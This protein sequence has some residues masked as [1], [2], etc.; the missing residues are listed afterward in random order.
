MEIE[1][2]RSALDRVRTYEGPTVAL[3]TGEVANSQQAEG[4]LWTNRRT[5]HRGEVERRSR[6]IPSSVGRL[7]EAKSRVVV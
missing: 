6:W 3:A 4:R 1:V 7:R 2:V 5:A